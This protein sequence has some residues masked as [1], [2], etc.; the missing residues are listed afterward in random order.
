MTVLDRVI[1]SDVVPERVLRLGIR[2]N[3]VAR[4]RQERGRSATDRAGF[5]RELGDSVRCLD[6]YSSMEAAAHK[7]DRLNGERRSAAVLA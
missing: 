6:R 7:A 1:A 2:A 3:L 5:V 4:L